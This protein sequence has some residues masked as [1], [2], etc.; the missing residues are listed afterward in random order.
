MV[1]VEWRSQGAILVFHLHFLPY[2]FPRHQPASSV[3]FTAKNLPF[4]SSIAAKQKLKEH[5][6]N[7]AH[8]PSK[9]NKN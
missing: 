1:K 4:S 5:H 8:F 9:H 6:K 7:P 2:S 3:I